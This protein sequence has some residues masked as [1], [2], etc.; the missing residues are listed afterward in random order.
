MVLDALE[1]KEN[2]D[3]EYTDFVKA[4]DKCDQGVLTHKMRDKEM[5]GKVG[6]WIYNF[7]K[8]RIQRVIVNRVK[9]EAATVK[10]SVPYSTV[11]APILFLILISDINSC[12]RNQM[13]MSSTLYEC[14]IS[15][16]DQIFSMELRLAMVSESKLVTLKS[17][18]RMIYVYITGNFKSELFKK[19]VENGY[20]YDNNFSRGGPVINTSEKTPMTKSLSPPEEVAAPGKVVDDDLTAEVRQRLENYPDDG[21]DSVAEV[22]PASL[23]E[24]TVEVE[25]HCEASPDQAMEDAIVTRMRAA[26]SDSDDVLTPV[27]RAGK[28]T[29]AEVEG[30]LLSQGPNLLVTTE[31]SGFNKINKEI[32]EVQGNTEHQFHG[33]MTRL[34][35]YL[36]QAM[37]FTYTYV[38]PSDELWGIKLDNGSWSGMMGMV[39][40]E[41]VG[42]GVGPFSIIISR[43]EVVD[44]TVPILIDYYRIL[45]GRGRPE[46][47]PWGFLFPLAPLVWAAILA[48]L[49]VLAA[50]LFFMSSIFS[51]KIDYQSKWLQVTFDYIRILLQQ[52]MT[53]PVYWWWER[54]MLVV[55]MMVTLVLTRSYSG[56]LMALL[57]VRHISQ[58]Y[59]SLRDVVDDPSVKIILEKGS[60]IFTY[61]NSA[62]S[63][64]YREIADTDKVGRLLLITRRHFSEAVDTLVRRGDHVL[65]VPHTGVKSYVAQDFTKTGICSFYG[66]REEFLKIMFAMIGPK[67]SPIIPAVNK[68]IFSMTE[69]GLFIQWLKIE[70]PN[71]TVCYHSPSKIAV[72]SPLSFTNTWGMYVILVAG[73]FSS[74]LLFCLHIIILR[75]L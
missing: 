6:K 59:Q 49:M 45:G 13:S 12:I 72:N 75:L 68:R 63:G 35:D 23:K 39:V 47:D 44:F 7:L 37:N 5:K 29:W 22:P 43:N 66:S 38:R 36:S 58:P 31:V 60:D 27:Q 26:A 73:Y 64:I 10:S 18:L 46:V 74:L 33:P 52:D 8:N 40:R 25:V 3:V 70:E 4:V 2:A 48:A 55:W 65:L 62:E 50:A 15:Y 17:W 61:L 32:Q 42:I 1:D 54:I 30:S 71:S 51:H 9:S 19:L 53:V 69:A 11:F 16:N 67:N 14:V 24:C 34:M 28:Q 20:N 21:S 57:A 41:E 56:N